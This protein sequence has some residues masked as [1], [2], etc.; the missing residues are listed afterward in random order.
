MACG[1]RA[2]HPAQLRSEAY[3]TAAVFQMRQGP[4]SGES[5]EIQSSSLAGTVVRG[6]LP[7]H[8]CAVALVLAAEHR[9][10]RTS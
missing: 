5:L 2:A 3:G 6:T 10:E 8:R 1:S 7:V 9:E 4:W